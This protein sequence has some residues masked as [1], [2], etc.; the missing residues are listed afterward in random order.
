MRYP[1]LSLLAC[2]LV[3]TASA[4]Q[5]L[6]A[7]APAETFAVLGFRAGGAETEVGQ[8]LA[9]DL[10]ALDWP[11][12]GRTLERLGALSGDPATGGLLE[13]YG[14]LFQGNQEGGMGAGDSR[15]GRCLQRQLEN[16][17]WEDVET[18]AYDAGL[19]AASASPYNPVP[20]GTA[21]LRV[22]SA[23]EAPFA[24]T[25]RALVR[26]TERTVG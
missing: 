22:T 9:D 12:A 15:F 8:A 21:L 20:A 13:L 11:R 2:L 19:V 3:G 25:H 24:A 10:G 6:A 5:P 14:Q 26:C 1:A 18:P 16:V 7:L 23:A 4:A 17:S